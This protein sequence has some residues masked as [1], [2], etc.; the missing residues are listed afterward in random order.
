[1]YGTL[2]YVDTVSHTFILISFLLSFVDEYDPTI[3]MYNLSTSAFPLPICFIV[4][5]SSNGSFTEG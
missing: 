3:G 1:M 5:P 4:L 2:N